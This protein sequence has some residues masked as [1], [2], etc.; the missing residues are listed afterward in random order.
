MDKQQ[1]ISL[2]INDLSVISYAKRV[3]K[4]NDLYKD[5]LSDVYIYIF[6]LENEKFEAIKDLKSYVCKIIYYAWNNKSNKNLLT[7]I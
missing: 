2:I 1:K 4:G 5:V 7:I 3:L 6:E